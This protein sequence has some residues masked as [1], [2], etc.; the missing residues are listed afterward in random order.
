[1]SESDVFRAFRGQPMAGF[2]GIL[3][4]DLDLIGPYCMPVFSKSF[5]GSKSM[6][7]LRC[8]ELDRLGRE[9]IEAYRP[10]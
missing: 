5:A 2:A 4:C 9:F 10:R 6:N 3:I 1:M 7:Y 8:P